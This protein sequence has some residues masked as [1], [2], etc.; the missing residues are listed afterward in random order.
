M[1]RTKSRGR[2]CSSGLRSHGGGPGCEDWTRDSR[3]LPD[4]EEG[5]HHEAIFFIFITQSMGRSCDDS[6]CKDPY[7]CCVTTDTCITDEECRQLPPCAYWSVGCPV[8]KNTDSLG[9]NLSEFE[10]PKDTCAADVFSETIT[11]TYNGIRTVVSPH[12]LKDKCFGENN[13]SDTITW[14]CSTS[15]GHEK[16]T[17]LCSDVFTMNFGTFKER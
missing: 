2:S 11:C 9:T 14:D 4:A 10:F 5:F 16:A 12:D 6:T 7:A 3:R 8:C 15:V 1:K 13:K 17:S